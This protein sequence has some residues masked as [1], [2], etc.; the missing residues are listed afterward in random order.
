MKKAIALLTALLVLSLWGVTA[1]A[2]DA[3]LDGG[4]GETVWPLKGNPV[5]MEKEYINIRVV[6][7]KSYVTCIFDFYNPG[8]ET[9]MLVGFPSEDV[10]SGYDKERDEHYYYD[11]RL[12]KFTTK[13]NGEKK[14]IKR[15]KGKVVY[16]KEMERTGYPIWFTWKMHFNKGER[17]RVVNTYWMNNSYYNGLRDQ[18]I[19]YIL[20]SGRN[21]KDAIGSV[22]VKMS[23]DKLLPYEIYA[24][25]GLAPTGMTADGSLLWEYKS[26]EPEEDIEVGVE[27]ELDDYFDYDLQKAFD[28]KRYKN[29]IKDCEKY[30]EENGSDEGDYYMMGRSY[31]ELKDYQKAIECFKLLNDGIGRYHEALTYLKMGDTMACVTIL[32]RMIRQPDADYPLLTLWARAQY[33]ACVMNWIRYRHGQ[34]D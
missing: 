22:C 16:D 7:G 2:D 18:E 32:E 11:M 27:S 23:F 20:Q 15:K 26:I 10:I 14:E 34:A 12:H 13:I 6:G 9:S 5:V 33:R 30:I 17:V 4:V 24:D 19:E 1:Y 29:V 31:Y 3:G 21:W 8:D 28:K 25:M